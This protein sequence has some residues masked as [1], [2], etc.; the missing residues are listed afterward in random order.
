MICSFLVRK[1]RKRTLFLT[2]TV[3]V[4]LAVLLRALVELKFLAS[5]N[6][7]A[8]ILWDPAEVYYQQK[9]S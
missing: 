1:D 5:S 2:L 6:I 7:K 9:M 4:L 8:L 3:F